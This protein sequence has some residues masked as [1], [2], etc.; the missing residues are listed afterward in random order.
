MLR[1]RAFWLRLPCSSTAGTPEALSCLAS[2]LAPCLVR[3]KTT[4]STG[5]RG[6]V[7]QHR[8]PAVVVTCSTWWVIV[9]TGD[10]AESAWCVAGS[11]GSA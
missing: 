3:V 11:S 2:F 9:E 8:Q 7:E 10:C 4:R 1:V 6:E 5:R